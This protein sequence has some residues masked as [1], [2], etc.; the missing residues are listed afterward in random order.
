[1][2]TMA[3]VTTPTVEAAA[4]AT[5]RMARRV[6]RTLLPPLLENERYIKTTVDG[7]TVPGSPRIGPEHV[8]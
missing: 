8:V 4:A 6:R 3:R 1:M 5:P 2:A 7:R